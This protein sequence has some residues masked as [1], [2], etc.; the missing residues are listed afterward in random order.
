MSGHGKTAV[1]PRVASGRRTRHGDPEAHLRRC[2]KDGSDY[3]WVGRTSQ[4]G[5]EAGGVPPRT[6]SATAICSG[7]L[8]WSRGPTA[9]RTSDSDE[10]APSCH[11]PMY[12]NG[13]Q[14]R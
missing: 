2:T 12:V 6:L 7:G 5:F 9:F 1:A 14:E 11:G 3:T 10:E 13:L 4:A 8:L